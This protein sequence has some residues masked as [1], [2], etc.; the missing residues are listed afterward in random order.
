MDVLEASGLVK[1]YGGQ[2]A[3][4]GFTLRVAAGE[5]AGLVGHNGAGKTTFAEVVTG[6]VRPEAGQVRV[7][8][9]NALTRPRAARRLV[10]AC[11]QET[12]LYPAATVAEHLRLF[13]ALAGLRGSGLRRAVDDIAGRMD[14]TS[15]ASKPTGLLS[16]GQRKRVQ[17]AT[18]LIAERPLL[19]LDEPT[20]GADPATRSRLL[21]VVADRAA[22]GAAVVYT[23][24]YLP[25]LVEL[26]ATVAVA[27]SGRVIARGAQRELSL[28]LVSELLG[29]AGGSA[30]PDATDGTGDGPRGAGWEDSRG[31][32]AA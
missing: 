2:R 3:L 22:A 20:V 28:D 12:A 1:T 27:E 17:A 14:L 16:G 26:G 32:D 4:D 18:A 21:A 8:G 7:R 24:H 25:E 5:I 11:P 13:G 9:V 6:L 15:V 19:L 31:A 29:A 10:S 30:G 23:T